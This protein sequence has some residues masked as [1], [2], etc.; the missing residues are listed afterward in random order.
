MSKSQD[1]TVTPPIAIPT[2]IPIAIPTPVPTPIPTPVKEILPELFSFKSTKEL[3]PKSKTQKSLIQASSI[4]VSKIKKMA[5]IKCVA[6]PMPLYDDNEAVAYQEP[7]PP[8]KIYTS[9]DNTPVRSRSFLN[10]IGNVTTRRYNC[11]IDIEKVQKELKMMNLK[12][13]RNTNKKKKKPK[14]LPSLNSNLK[15]SLVSKQIFP[16]TKVKYS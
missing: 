7:E 11:S 14:F 12:V 2:A 10:T 16:L 4:K 15:G 8:K 5:A 9:R 1:R 3:R 13:T 6:P